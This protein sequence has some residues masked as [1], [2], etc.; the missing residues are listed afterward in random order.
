VTVPEGEPMAVD[1]NPQN[2]TRTRDDFP[3][4]DK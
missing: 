2:S 1:L 3:E 4:D